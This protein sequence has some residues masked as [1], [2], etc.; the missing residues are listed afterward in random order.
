MIN[1]FNTA[2]CHVK[3]VRGLILNSHQKEKKFYFFDFVSIRDDGY[4]LNLLWLSF[5]DACKADH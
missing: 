3:L 2:V 1:T 4:S 5:Y